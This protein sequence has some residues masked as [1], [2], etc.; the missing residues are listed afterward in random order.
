MTYTLLT[1]RGRVRPDRSA[2]RCELCGSVSAHPRDV[3]ERYCGWCHLF[4]DVVAQ[5]RALAAQPGAAH[6]CSEWRTGRHVCAL[7]AR[8]LAPRD[9]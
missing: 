9:A 2:I 5:A 3:A 7:C 1:I 4:H 6:D 8:P